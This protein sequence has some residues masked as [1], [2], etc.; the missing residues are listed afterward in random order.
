MASTHKR[1]RHTH[2]GNRSWRSDWATTPPTSR[3]RPPRARSTSTTGR[4]TAG[5]CCSRHPKDFTPVCTTELGYTAKLKPRVRQAQREGH[6]PLG[7][8]A[9][10]TTRAGPRTSRRPRASRPNFPLIAD[11]DRKVAD[12]Y[13]MIHPNANDTADGALGV[14][15]RPRQQGEAHAHLPGAAPAA[16][17]TRSSGSS[18]R[19]SSPPSYKVATPVNWKDGEDVIIVAGRLRRGGQGALPD[20]WDAMKPY[21]RITKQPNS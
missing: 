20:G 15:D 19:C 1:P 11:A 14:R 6:R 18:T 7:R 9:S 3:P 12:L 8:P 5:R 4:A 10:R 16:T 17:S 2:R 21:L 13:D